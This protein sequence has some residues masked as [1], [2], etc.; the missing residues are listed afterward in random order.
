ML[1]CRKYYEFNQDNNVIRLHVIYIHIYIYI[2][3]YIYVFSQIV[4]QFRE[5][6]CG[7]W[8]KYSRYIKSVKHEWRLPHNLFSISIWKMSPGKTEKKHW[9][10]LIPFNWFSSSFH[11]KIALS[12]HLILITDD[13]ENIFQGKNLKKYIFEVKIFLKTTVKSQRW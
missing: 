2:Y 12:G 3:I 13:L 11:Q 4:Q 7:S 8:S 1:T 9:I 6:Y 10:C 5:F